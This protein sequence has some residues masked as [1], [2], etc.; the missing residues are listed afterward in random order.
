MQRD[1]RRSR[2]ATS[3]E[4]RYEAAARRC[5]TIAP[6]FI[7]LAVAASVDP[8]SRRA[9]IPVV[10]R[11]LPLLAAVLACTLAHADDIVTLWDTAYVSVR[12]GTTEHLILLADMHPGYM[13]VA[14]QA[15][16]DQLVLDI[17]RRAE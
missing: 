1:D 2:R 14:H 10:N 17:E 16:P 15:Q 12:P 9:I 4:A 6:P 7:W 13:V 5:D 8:L 11:V 3:A